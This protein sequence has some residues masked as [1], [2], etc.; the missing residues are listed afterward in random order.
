M[1]ERRRSSYFGRNNRSVQCS[2]DRLDGCVFPCLEIENAIRESF[3][4]KGVDTSDR[5]VG[6]FDAKMVAPSPDA[7]KMP[8]GAIR[9]NLQELRR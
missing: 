1:E 9:L 3:K 8:M 4:A 6:A 5:G 2:H 7:M